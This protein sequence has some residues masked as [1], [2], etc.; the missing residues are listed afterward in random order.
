MLL[1]V[2]APTEAAAVR[3]GIGL[4]GPSRDPAP[5]CPV[6][7]APGADLLLTGVGKA[8]AAGAVAATLACGRYGLVIN[9][10]IAGALPAGPA[11]APIGA[12]VFA[13]ASIFADEGVQAEQ[14]FR[15]LAELGWGTAPDGTDVLRPD[16]G[17]AT[18]LRAL[19]TRH[20]TVATVSTCS[21][22]DALAAE[23][24]RRTNAIAEAME[25]AAVLLAAA[26]AGVP[27]A[28]IRVVS[29]TT[30]DRARQQWDIAAAMNRL[31]TLAA[32]TLDATATRWPGA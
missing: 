22:T 10:G 9:L 25:G 28:E 15:S 20:G 14:A 18:S 32:G 29:N 19:A 26:R 8:N 17:L 2:A 24:V 3:R 13:E 16:P 30:G 4:D 11:P 23:V 31:S 21:G 27:A 5:W 6:P 12:V 1:V 7:L